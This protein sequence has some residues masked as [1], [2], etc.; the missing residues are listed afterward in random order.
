MYRVLRPQ[1]F[2]ALNRLY[3]GT[4]CALEFGLPTAHLQIKDSPLTDHNLLHFEIQNLCLA[5]YV[6]A[7]FCKLSHSFKHMSIMHRWPFSAKGGILSCRF[8]LPACTNGE[9]AMTVIGA[10][11]LDSVTIKDPPPTTAKDR[12]L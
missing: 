2:H 8:R 4:L 12:Q 1:H 11:E 6:R 9:L 10:R 7:S 5:R 3:L